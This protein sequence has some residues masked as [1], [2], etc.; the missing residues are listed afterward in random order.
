VSSAIPASAVILDADNF[1]LTDHPTGDRT[2]VAGGIN[3]IQFYTRNATSAQYVAAIVNDSGIGGLGSMALSHANSGTGNAGNQIIGILSQP[4]TLAATG[5][6]I[7][8]SFR[9]RYTNLATATHNNSGFRF[10]LEGSNGTLVTGDNQGTQSNN[11]QGYYVQ[12]GTGNAPLGPVPLANNTLYREN[13]AVGPV[14]P[15]LG[16]TDRQNLTTSSTG[17]T[18]NDELPHSASLTITRGTGT[19]MSFSVV[20]DNGT[21]ITA[22]STTVPFYHFDEVA[23]GDAFVTNSIHFRVDD[24]QV[25]TNVP[26]PIAGLSLLGGAGLLLARRRRWCS[27]AL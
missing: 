14:P 19:N 11:D 7:T 1:E 13:G 16:G 5:D 18:F 9:F 21:P 23:F 6:F 3:G 20:Y 27:R 24:V 12:T 26:E 17:V 10:G 25:T 8:L 22:T 4:I 15:I 2:V